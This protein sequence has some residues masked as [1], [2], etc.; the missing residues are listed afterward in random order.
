MS[1]PDVAKWHLRPYLIVF[2]S[3]HDVDPDPDPGLLPLLDQGLDDHGLP[4]RVLATANLEIETVG[5]ASLNEEGFGLFHIG[6]RR[7]Q[8]C[9]LGMHRT[10]V[11]MLGDLTCFT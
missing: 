9:I 6:L 2:G 1:P 7:R 5:Q 10:D 3:G 11:M 8:G 4:A